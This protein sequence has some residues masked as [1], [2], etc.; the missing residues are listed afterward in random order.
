[1]DL[2][3]APSSTGWVCSIAVLQGHREAGV[4][5]C[6]CWEQPQEHFSLPWMLKLLLRLL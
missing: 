1:M 6:G 5:H 2:A 3:V 4:P